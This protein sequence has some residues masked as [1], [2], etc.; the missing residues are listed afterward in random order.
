LHNPFR[1]LEEQTLETRMQRRQLLQ[2]LAGAAAALAAPT[3]LW[4]AEYPDKA[5]RVLVPFQAGS[6]PDIWARGIASELAKKM[7]Q[8]FVVENM[9]G[10]GGSI[11]A[12][13]VKR[14]APDGYTLGLFANTQAITAHT[15]KNPPYELSKDFV[16]VAPL[17]GGVSLLTVPAASPIHSGKELIAALKA[18][19]GEVPFASGGN[20][21]VAHL[22][23]EQLLKQTGTKALHVPYKGSP[24]IISSQISGQTDFGMPIFGSALSFVK[25]GQLRALAI[26]GEKRS[27]LLPDVPTLKEALPPGFTLSSW[28]G[29]FAP[30]KTPAPIVQRLFKEIDAV[31]RS[32][33][34][35]TLAEGMG[36][37]IM[38]LES[39]QAFQAFVNA[40][41]QRFGTLMKQVDVKVD[42][43]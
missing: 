18:K 6:T 37:D 28:A 21:S 31:M 15:F 35:N 33:T 17:G 20:G 5:I 23:V 13:T 2:S 3:S 26:T 12:S 34:L 22:A 38:T 8:A 40:E 16:A 39:Q 14:A 4:A 43:R 30:A 1:L 24:D 32:G 29:V 10:A 11:G 25:G 7:G 27:P 42:G 9:P 19:P 41:D 36:S